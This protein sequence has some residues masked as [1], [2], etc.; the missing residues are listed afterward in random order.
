MRTR[1]EQSGS[2]RSSEFPYRRRENLALSRILLE[3]GCA[4]GFAGS[5]SRSS[6]GDTSGCLSE[7]FRDTS[8]LCCLSMANR[9]RNK[10]RKCLVFV[11]KFPTTIDACAAPDGGLVWLLHSGLPAIIVI[12]TA[13][14]V[15]SRFRKYPRDTVNQA[16]RLKRARMS[17]RVRSTSTVVAAKGGK[18]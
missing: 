1:K 3:P 13:R 9:V 5:N 2:E 17:R 10:T 16:E 8:R 12:A 15:G 14:V 7:S 18:P 6:L 11:Q 4:R